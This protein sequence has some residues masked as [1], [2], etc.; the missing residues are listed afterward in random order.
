M[1]KLNSFFSQ[2][3][4]DKW[5]LSVKLNFNLWENPDI[6][7]PE[8]VTPTLPS[9]VSGDL[10]IDSVFFLTEKCPFIK[11]KPIILV[12]LNSLPFFFLAALSLNSFHFPCF[13]AFTFSI[14]VYLKAYFKA[15][16]FFFLVFLISSVSSGCI[17]KWSG[18]L[19][20]V[21]SSIYLFL[22]E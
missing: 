10:N 7:L 3:N 8:L 4:L 20:S 11:L 5:E 1:S 2:N 22:F 9:I 13:S 14:L 17:F 15:L 19:N 18:S 21:N 16:I 6:P 12:K